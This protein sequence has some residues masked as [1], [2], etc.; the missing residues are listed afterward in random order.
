M[1][2]KA[3]S[4]PRVAY[5]SCILIDKHDGFAE[6]NFTTSNC[7]CHPCLVTPYN[8]DIKARY[9]FRIHLS[10]RF[11]ELLSYFHFPN[12]RF[13]I[14][15]QICTALWHIKTVN[16]SVCTPFLSKFTVVKDKQ[17]SLKDP[18]P[19]QKG[20]L[21]KPARSRSAPCLGYSIL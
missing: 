4:N 14:H 7:S 1:E 19:F 16:L 10:D 15:L 6:G 12:S 13:P 20:I 11:H 5:R 17:P 18:F 3:L 21:R 2:G 9:T 8:S